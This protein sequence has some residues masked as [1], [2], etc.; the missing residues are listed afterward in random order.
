MAL[1]KPQLNGDV[2]NYDEKQTAEM[3][4]LKPS[5]VPVNIIVG[6]FSTQTIS[7]TSYGVRV[8]VKLGN[9]DYHSSAYIPRELFQRWNLLKDH[10]NNSVMFRVASTGE[11]ELWSGST[12]GSLITGFY[13]YK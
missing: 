3:N 11:I 5:V 9:N 1:P 8:N 4:N 6:G 2:L 7:P 12:V 10:A 13:E